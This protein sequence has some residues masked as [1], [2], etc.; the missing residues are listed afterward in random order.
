MFPPNLTQT[1][2]QFNS[3]AFYRQQVRGKHCILHTCSNP[4]LTQHT[5]REISRELTPNIVNTELYNYCG[6]RVIHWCSDDHRKQGRTSGISP[7]ATV[8]RQRHYQWPGEGS[9]S[10]LM[11]KRSISQWSQHTV[12]Q[13]AMVDNIVMVS[14]LWRQATDVWV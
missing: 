6:H 9:S 10:S 5:A 1:C 12:L 14:S 13:L 8:T 7:L 2:K 4:P 3:S 11:R